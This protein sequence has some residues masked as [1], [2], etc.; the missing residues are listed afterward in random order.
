MNYI[1]VPGAWAAS[2]V[3][4]EV[5]ANLTAQGHK[6][7]A[8]TLSGLGEGNGAKHVGLS[9]HVDDVIEYLNSNNIRSA[10]L[11]GHSYSGIV[12][13]MVAQKIPH[14]I[15]HTVF[16]EA[17]LPVKDRSLLDVSGLDVDDELRAISVN[18]GLWPAPSGEELSNQP[19][20]TDA[21]VTLLNEKQKDHPGRT[22]SDTVWREPHLGDLDATF[23]A[24]EQWLADSPLSELLAGLRKKPNW[25][26]RAIDGG[27]WPMLTIPDDLARQLTDI[28]A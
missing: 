20:L 7:H 6:V 15:A 27:H 28:A 26:F 24:H 16:V 25:Q 18:D 9:T 1:L 10:I 13:G 11:V 19:R 2:W 3:W 14:R 17:F 22:V 21:L 5:A 23:I 12:I 4:K 8:L